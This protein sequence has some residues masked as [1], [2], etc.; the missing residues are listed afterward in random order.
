MHT[1]MSTCATKKPLKTS[2]RRSFD[3]AGDDGA[4]V[5][6]EA[7]PEADAATEA[8]AEAEVVGAAAAT[9]ADAG[10]AVEVVAARERLDGVIMTDGRTVRRSDRTHTATRRISGDRS[11]DNDND[12]D[13]TAFAQT[14]VVVAHLQRLLTLVQSRQRQTTNTRR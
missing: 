4:D 3:T 12:N 8:E 13:V 2:I 10:G 7:A 1:T 5:G 11:S 14:V 6:A 9:A